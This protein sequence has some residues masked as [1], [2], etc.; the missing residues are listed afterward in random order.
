[1]GSRKRQMH[2]ANILMGSEIYDPYGVTGNSTKRILAKKLLSES[3]RFKPR[4]GQYPHSQGLAD[5]AS[6]GLGLYSNYLANQEDK[7]TMEAYQSEKADTVS[8]ASEFMQP[9]RRELP[10]T[11]AP[12]G[13]QNPDIIRPHGEDFNPGGPKPSAPADMR[14]DFTGT[15]GGITEENVGD[16]QDVPP[17]ILSAAN[18]LI[19]SRDPGLQQ[20]G[21]SMM[22]KIAEKALKDD[23]EFE[24]FKRKE[25]YKKELEDP[26]GPDISAFAKVNPKDFTAASVTAFNKS[27]ALGKPDHSL[28]MPRADRDVFKFNDRDMWLSTNFGYKKEDLVAGKVSPEHMDGWLEY[29]GKNRFEKAKDL[30]DQY[31]KLASPFIA[32]RDAHGRVMASASNPDSAGDLALIF[33]YM[34]VLDPGSV[35]RESEFATAAASGSFGERIKALVGRISAGERLSGEMRADF[36]R[37][38]KKLYQQAQADNRTLTKQYSGLAKRAKV[39]PENVVFEIKITDMG[40]KKGKV[41]TSKMPDGWTREEWNELTEDEKTEWYQSE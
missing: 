11:R 41:D 20:A 29:Q 15:H 22:Q 13:E 34:K 37:R 18:T 25:D 27:V 24:L 16:V 6:T 9:T 2:L 4:N 38:S 5:L 1:M 36:V 30:R 35:V 26:E 32:Q 7:A 28:L 40:T 10:V 17:D 21:F 14:P 23:D 3:G 8:K 33:N 19:K 12:I 39:N 31:V